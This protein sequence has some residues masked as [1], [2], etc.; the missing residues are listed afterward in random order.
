MMILGFYDFVV[1][2]SREELGMLVGRDS[3]G[4]VIL[5]SLASVFVSA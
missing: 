3:G 4:I 2:D 5:G 1:C